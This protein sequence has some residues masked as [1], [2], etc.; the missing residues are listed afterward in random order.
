M[1]SN[2][3]AKVIVLVL[4]FLFICGLFPT[5][6]TAI[7]SVNASS[8]VKAVLMGMPFLFLGLC[9]YAVIA[10]GKT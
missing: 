7:N 4:L 1:E 2:T 6:M 5:M 8:P 10:G 3:T 9:I